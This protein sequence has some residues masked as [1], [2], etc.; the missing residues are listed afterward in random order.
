[1]ISSAYQL[2]SLFVVVSDGI[3]IKVLP[4]PLLQGNNVVCRHSCRA[5]CLDG[6]CLS[7]TE[8]ILPRTRLRF[9]SSWYALGSP[10][11][12]YRWSLDLWTL[13]E[14]TPQ[15]PTIFYGAKLHCEWLVRLGCVSL[16][17]YELSTILSGNLCITEIVLLIRISSWNFVRVPK[18]MLCEALVKQHL[19]LHSTRRQKAYNR[20]RRNEF[21]CADMIQVVEMT[22]YMSN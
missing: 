20:D 1:M 13:Y 14:R 9:P 21:F 11:W 12:I 18:A 2:K 16:T 3:L 15:V 10:R 8:G 22:W 17:F 19:G 4:S 7:Q 5:E 6:T